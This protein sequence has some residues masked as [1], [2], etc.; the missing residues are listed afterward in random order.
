MAL[1]VELK[2]GERIIIGD[3]VITNDNQRDPSVY[4]RPGPHSA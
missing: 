2:P 4:R 3:S 1:K